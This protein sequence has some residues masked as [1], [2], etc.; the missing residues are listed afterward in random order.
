MGMKMK[1]YIH[2]IVVLAV[3]AVLAVASVEMVFAVDDIASGNYYG[4]DWRIT[5][6]NRLILGR[7]GTTQELE[8]T[9]ESQDPFPWRDKSLHGK[10]T[11]AGIEGSIA[12]NGDMSEMFCDLWEMTAAV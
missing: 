1:R 3:A 7:E 6:D 4:V 10:I 8:F 5:S 9:G 11:A 12:V 2:Y